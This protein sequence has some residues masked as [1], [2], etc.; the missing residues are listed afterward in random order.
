MW[1]FHHLSPMSYPGRSIVRCPFFLF[2]SLS[3][4]VFGVRFVYIINRVFLGHSIT[5]KLFISLFSLLFFLPRFRS[6]AS[7]FH[8]LFFPVYIN[9][10]VLSFI[11]D[12]RVARCSERA[13][14]S[15][16]PPSISHE[17]TYRKKYSLFKE[18]IE[19]NYSTMSFFQ[20]AFNAA[21]RGC[22]LVSIFQNRSFFFST[23]AIDT[24]FDFHLK[25]Q[26]NIS[27][28]QINKYWRP[29]FW[30]FRAREKNCLTYIFNL[31]Q[32][33][34]SC[35]R[36]VDITNNLIIYLS[37]TFFS[38]TNQTKKIVIF[39]SSIVRCMMI[40]SKFQKVIVI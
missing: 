13:A 30:T 20:S 33:L 24:N 8:C 34:T 39:R 10:L 29:Q 26:A 31:Y 21:A 7:L 16:T 15:C 37:Q 2:P 19:K 18:R 32:C 14:G 25:I 27:E 23:L 35:T 6:F 1:I 36:I 38:F 11:H 28:R 5:P 3:L 4:S 40:W 22:I 12:S 9:F 17:Q